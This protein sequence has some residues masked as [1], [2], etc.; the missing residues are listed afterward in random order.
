MIPDMIK[1]ST[2]RIRQVL[3]HNLF[4]MMGVNVLLLIVF[5]FWGK[6]IL[7]LLYSK[8]YYANAYPYLI[9]LTIGNI[10]V[11]FASVFGAYMTASGHQD[12][13]LKTMTVAGFI[14]LCAIAVCHRF[15]LY[16]AVIAYIVSASFMGA[17][18]FING[19]KILNQQKLEELG[20]K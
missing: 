19:I 9:L 16:A 3:K 20:E 12:I 13:K 5:A 6:D 10:A 15:G 11:S 17:V 8:E 1:V 18:Y 14:T 7:V 4:F 2:E